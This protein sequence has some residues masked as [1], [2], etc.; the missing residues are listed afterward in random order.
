MH[1]S[2]YT[3]SEYTNHNI[4]S[5]PKAEKKTKGKKRGALISILLEKKLE[6]AWDRGMSTDQFLEYN[7]VPPPV[8]FDGDELITT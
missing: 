3:P 4:N 5:K 8:L 2:N 6:I 7:V 1:L